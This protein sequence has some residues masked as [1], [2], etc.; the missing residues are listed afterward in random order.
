MGSQ[1]VLAIAL[2]PQL[3]VCVARP[4]S[5]GD[6]VGPSGVL[7]STMLHVVV[8]SS[9]AEPFKSYQTSPTDVELG[10]VL[11]MWE[12]STIPRALGGTGL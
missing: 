11:G 2:F 6:T 3:E 5:D 12:V 9:L 1:H 7:A 4:F 10:A 8:E